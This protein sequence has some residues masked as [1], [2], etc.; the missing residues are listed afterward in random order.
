MARDCTRVHCVCG[1][2]VDKRGVAG[3]GWGTATYWYQVKEVTPERV[4]VLSH[5]TVTLGLNI[6]IRD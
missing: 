6:I 3:R 2:K 5:V 1:V 4:N